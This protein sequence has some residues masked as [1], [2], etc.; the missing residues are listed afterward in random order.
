M[1][2]KIKEFFGHS[3]SK[4]F[5][6]KNK[7]T[8]FVRKL[9]NVER[10]YERMHSLKKNNFPVP[11]VY[12]FDSE[13]LDMEYIH[14]ID[15]KNYLRSNNIEKLFLFLNEILNKFSEKSILKDYTKTYEEKLKG[16]DEK[17]FF[18]FKMQQL[19]EKLPKVL[20]QSIYHGDMT[21]E[22]ILMTKK[23]FHFIDPITSVYDSYIFDISKLR[24]DLECKWF[25]RNEDIKIDVKLKDLQQK[26]LS[27]FP[28]ADNNSLLI[29]MLL[30]VIPNCEINDKNYIF[31]TDQI[32][33]L[34][35][36]IE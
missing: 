25:L 6:M 32:E 34:W 29:L 10:N 36:Q 5:L 23:G 22:N 7:E 16:F 17:Y 19:I 3:G 15:M 21:L 4:V 12:H 24:Q 20:P 1:E 2:K 11:D 8:I 13:K 18:S 27:K 31:L 33:K 30:R 28:V 9:Y 26:I 35:K 14:G